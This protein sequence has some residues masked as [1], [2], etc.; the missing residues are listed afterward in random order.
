MG[1]AY[2]G[3]ETVRL[4][5]VLG[6]AETG[7]VMSWLM[8]Y[9]RRID[10]GKIKIDFYMYSPS[11]YDDEIRRSGGRVFYYPR[12]T[13]VF[14]AYRTLKKAFKENGY[15]V[16]H[17]HMT[18]LSF[19]ALCAA[20]SASVGRRICHAHSTANRGEGWKWAVKTLIR[21]LNRLF[22][23]EYAGCSEESIRWL[24]GEKRAK[25]AIL[26]HNAV[27]VSRFLPRAPEVAAAAPDEDEGIGTI[28]FIGRFERQKNVGFLID[29][30]KELSKTRANVRLLLAGAGSEEKELK[31]KAAKEGLGGAVEFCSWSGNVEK[32]YSAID[33]LTLP[34]LFE[35][36]PLVAVEAQA[37]G[38]PCV[39]SGNV[40]EEAAVTKNCVFVP[41]NDT[42]AWVR[43]L[44]NALDA[45]RDPA[46]A[47]T[48][49][50][51]DYDIEAEAARLEKYYLN[52]AEV[53]ERNR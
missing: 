14:G 53:N 34:S 2:R 43:A 32:Y 15:D 8:N 23:T 20:R 51:S 37:A 45:G 10:R 29:V 7:G 18:T 4:A 49:K 19:V 28:G 35:G 38:I 17:V 3:G 36:L 27:D 21:P 30:F 6:Y 44:E 31:D 25:N 5:W 24:Y 11:P 9:F 12:V 16:V 1:G 33:V 41:L 47:L 39:L 42:A 13:H 40:T 46:E 22:A 26:I 48:L 52:G 50:G